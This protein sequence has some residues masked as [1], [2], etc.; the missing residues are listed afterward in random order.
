MGQPTGTFQVP[1][2]LAPGAYNIYI[3]ESNTTPLPGNGPNDAYQTARGTSLGTVLSTTPL[4]VEGVMVVKTSTTAYTDGGYSKA[5]DTINYS[6][7]VTNQGPDTVTNITVNDNKIPSVDITCPSSSLAGGTSETCTGTYTVTQADVDNGS[8]TNTAT[9]SATSPSNEVL[10]SAPSSVTVNASDATSSLSLVKSTTSTGYG[11]AG[12]TIPYSYLVTNTGTTTESNI[13]V[14]D[15]LIANVSCP[16]SSLAGGAS[17]ICT[18]TY[19]VTQADVD[20]GS[21][22][23]TATASGT[24]PASTTEHSNSSTV[25]VLASNAVSSLSLTKSTTSTGYGA[26]GN[27]IPYSYL[28]T[29]TGTTTESGVGVTDSLIATVNCPDSSLAP[30]AS[31]TCT[32]SYTVTQVDVD[33]G[34]VTNTATANATNPYANAISSN[35]SS[36]TVEASQATSTLSLAKST[37]STGYGSAGEIIPYTYLVTN[38]GTTTESGVGVSDNKVASVSCPDPT[39]APAASETCTGSYTVTQADVDR[40]YVTNT[41]TASATNPQSV[42]I[43]SGPSSVTV[44]ATQATSSLSLSKSTTSDGYGTAGTVLNY[45]YLVTNSGTTTLSAVGVTDNLVSDV[46]CPDSSLAPGASETCTGS[47]TVTQAD[48]DAGSV[49]NTAFATATDVDSSTVKSGS[50]TVVVE[51]SLATSSLSIVKSTNSSG[52]GAAG[53][54][55]DY[56]YLVT[57]TGTTDLSAVGVN[58]NLVSNVSCPDSSSPPGRRRPARAATP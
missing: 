30:G 14:S 51:A 8:V 36:V 25:T 16:S 31:E 35:S 4:D 24:N 2:G 29:N 37:T 34:S 15:N 6:Y 17:E 32:G 50:S 26:A 42:T 46:N 40:G 57:N 11:A 52:Y 3:E 48:V 5:G 18:A 1:S 9:V 28:V 56:S 39:L 43:T 44:D 53:D 20:N 21:V 49:T 22:T 27:T 7:A 38:T 54:V 55:I 45:S 47:Y 58:D 10:T 41:A 19:T 12:N 13:A 23:N 33:N